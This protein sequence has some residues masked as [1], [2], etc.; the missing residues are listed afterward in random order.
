LHIAGEPRLR[1]LPGNLRTRLRERGRDTIAHKRGEASRTDKKHPAHP[2][3]LSSARYRAQGR[4][5]RRHPARF[6][7][8]ALSRPSSETARGPVARRA[9]PAPGGPDP[10]RKRDGRLPCRPGCRHPNGP[11]AIRK[12]SPLNADA[13]QDALN[14]ELVLY[15]QLV[16]VEVA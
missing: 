15:A 14:L 4:N 1:R 12:C 10:K 5:N 9:E 11:W 2:V 8:A 13:E 6:L 16:V 3:S 7:P